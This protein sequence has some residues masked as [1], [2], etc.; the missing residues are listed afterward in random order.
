MVSSEGCLQESREPPEESPYSWS[1]DL[2]FLRPDYRVLINPCANGFISE[3]ASELKAISIHIHI[4]QIGH[5]KK[6]G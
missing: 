2:A 6:G 3:G 1:K 4:N 5:G